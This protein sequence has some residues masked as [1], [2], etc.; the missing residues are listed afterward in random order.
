MFWI[1]PQQL[2]RPRVPGSHVPVAA[3]GDLR[4]D[5]S[6]EFSAPKPLRNDVGISVWLRW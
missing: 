1:W 5:G 4:Y 3:L 6:L 2:K